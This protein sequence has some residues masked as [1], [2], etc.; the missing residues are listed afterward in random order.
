MLPRTLKKNNPNSIFI[1]LVYL[2]PLIVISLMNSTS[3]FVWENIGS[4]DPVFRALGSITWLNR[5]LAIILLVSTAFYLQYLFYHFRLYQ[6]GN[7]YTVLI[8]MGVL[9]SSDYALSI[10]VWS[11][12]PLLIARLIHKSIEIQSNSYPDMLLLEAGFIS[13][14]LWLIHPGLS[15]FFPAVLFAYLYSGKISVKGLL[16]TLLGIA[17]PIYFSSGI[18]YLL[19]VPY[20]LKF[21][22]TFEQTTVELQKQYWLFIGSALLV[23]FSI[24][25][26]LKALVT[27]KNI[28]KN[29]LLLVLVFSGLGTLSVLSSNASANDLLVGFFPA[30]AVMSS[31]FF[32]NEN[33]TW[34]SELLFI[35]WYISLILHLT[36]CC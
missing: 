35:V 5:G 30:F 19:D 15:L 7:Q 3:V 22:P 10:S 17:L 26:Y 2:L 29:H 20:Q 9:L 32:L 4:L 36:S 27:N 8:T 23:F 16:V 6:T 34:L 1:S 11:I 24:R 31:L 25:Y 14:L 12:A 13:G 18:F 21:I 33:R 28:V